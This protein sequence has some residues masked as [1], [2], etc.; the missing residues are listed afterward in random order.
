MSQRYYKPIEKNCHPNELPD[1]DYMVPGCKFSVKNG[2]IG[3]VYL[4]SNDLDKGVQFIQEGI[5][6]LVHGLLAGV[7]LFPFAGDVL[8]CLAVGCGLL[9]TSNGKDER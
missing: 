5:V 4:L 3:Y 9:W 7:S 8:F 2:I 6:L 1:G